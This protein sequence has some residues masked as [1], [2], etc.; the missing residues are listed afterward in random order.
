MKLTFV[1]NYI[2]HHQIP[3][4]N[5]LYD[6]LGADYTFVQTEPME[7]ERRAMGW[8]D[9]VS[10][11]PYLKYAYETPEECRRL[12]M[13]SDIVVFGGTEEE[14][15]IEERLQAGRITI[16]YSERLYREG[17]WKAI[18][19]RGLLKKYHDHTRYRNAPVYLLCAGAYVASDFHIVRAYPD[20]MF[21]WGYFTETKHYDVDKLLAEKGSRKSGTLEILFAGRFLPLKHPQY[22]IFL[23]EELKKRDIPFHLTMVGGG[24]MDEWLRSDV[25]L[26]GLNDIVFFTGF[27]R[28]EEVRSYMERADIFLM[29]SNYLEGWGAVINEAMNSGCAVLADAKIG[30]VPFLVRHGVS[31]M[32]YADGNSAEFLKLGTALATD[33]S[34]REKIARNAYRTITEAWNP[35][36]AAKRLLLFAEGL[37]FGEVVAAKDGPLSP[38]PVIW[39]HAGYQY[40][41]R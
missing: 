27:K 17:Q 9:E 38:A 3:V 7:E 5:A 21:R 22:A 24:E 19:P 2:N 37:L 30:A 29:T 18:S 35:E 12:I 13:D 36:E 31:G 15:Y 8:N 20:K 10:A 39:P 23:A 26:R 14:R 34:L 6:S 32:V 41:R 16:R 1:S 25:R 28:P 33:A 11:L 4:S 40:V